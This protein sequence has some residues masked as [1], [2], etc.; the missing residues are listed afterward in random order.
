MCV[1]AYTCAVVRRGGGTLD[2]TRAD[3]YLIEKTNVTSALHFDLG[4]IMRQLVVASLLFSSM[5][6]MMWAACAEAQTLPPNAG[7]RFFSLRGWWNQV[8]PTIYGYGPY[9]YGYGPEVYGVPGYGPLLGPAPYGTLLRPLERVSPYE[10]LRPDQIPSP[11]EIPAPRQL[12]SE[13]RADVREIREDVDEIK[14]G[15]D[16]LLE[17]EK[18]EREKAEE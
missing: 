1:P 17:L 9:G 3:V 6:V 15:L 5:I 13:L 12:A 7:L 8:P 14:M 4:E 2:Y 10:M 11:Y 18:E 16:K